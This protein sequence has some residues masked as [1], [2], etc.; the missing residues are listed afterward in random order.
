MSVIPAVT[1]SPSTDPQVER[2]AVRSEQLRIIPS[3]GGP[4]NGETPNIKTIAQPTASSADE[5]KVQWD[6]T[7]QVVVYQFI[8]QQ[9]SLVLQVPSEQLLNLARD[10]S[11]ELTQEAVPKPT[12]TEGVN[13]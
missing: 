10:I 3:S 13:K 9:G 11:Q 7:D 1:L 6:Q 4:A 2:A 8:N 5:V 12:G